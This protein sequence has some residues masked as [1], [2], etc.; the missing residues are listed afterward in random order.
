VT[1]VKTQFK[2]ADDIFVMKKSKSRFGGMFEKESIKFKKQS[3]IVTAEDAQILMTFFD[4]I[5]LGKFKM[6]LELFKP[7]ANPTNLAMLE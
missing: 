5:A 4:V 7:L 2:I 1:D 6:T 3:H